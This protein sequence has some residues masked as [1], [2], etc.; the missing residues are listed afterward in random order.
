MSRQHRAPLALVA[1]SADRPSTRQNLR[2]RLRRG[3][4][5]WALSW[6]EIYWPAFATESAGLVVEPL[7]GLSDEVTRTGDGGTA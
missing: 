6:A 7:G 4:G 1:G 5:A 2:Y 3:I